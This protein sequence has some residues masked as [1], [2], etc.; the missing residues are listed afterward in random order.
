MCALSLSDR[1]TKESLSSDIV[2]NVV[3]RRLLISVQ[4]VN[5]CTSSSIN[6]HELHNLCS[7]GTF[8]RL[9]LPRIISSLFDW[10][11]RRDVTEALRRYRQVRYRG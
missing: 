11:L 5:K 1:A 6:L 7:F 8:G 9:Y 3:F 4:F 10:S 2:L